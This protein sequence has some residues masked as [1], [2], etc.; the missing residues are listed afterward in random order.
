MPMNNDDRVFRATMRFF[1]EDLGIIK[2]EV[3][4]GTTGS[5]NTAFGYQA[6]KSMTTGS[7][8]V[9]IGAR[10]GK[11]LSTNHSPRAVAFRA[12][13]AAEVK[14][15]ADR[16]HRNKMKHFLIDL[17]VAPN[18]TYAFDQ[19]YMGYGESISTYGGSYGDF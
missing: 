17:G 13:E 8:N 18:P 2:P 16:F 10:A 12:K 9:A 4:H 3:T 6:M 19:M 11:T 14:E 5:Y 1:L 15:K 7:S